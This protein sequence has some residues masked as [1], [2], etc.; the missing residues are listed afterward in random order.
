VANGHSM[1]A[2][3]LIAAGADAGEAGAAG[4]PRT[5]P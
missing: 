1:M 3:L 5:A 4:E 2:E